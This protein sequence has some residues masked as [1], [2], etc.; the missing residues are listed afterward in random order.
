[1]V[2]EKLNARPLDVDRIITRRSQ[3]LSG[4]R[5]LP[6][7]ISR[8]LKKRAVGRAQAR[9]LLIGGDPPDAFK[10]APPVIIVEKSAGDVIRRIVVKC[11]C[12]RHA[13]LTCEYE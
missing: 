12:G 9:R 10:E 5:P 13:E 1:M 7:T 6:V 2:E 4:S 3:G 11:P 8:I